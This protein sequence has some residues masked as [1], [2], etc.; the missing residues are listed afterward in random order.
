M[1][2]LHTAPGC[3]IDTARADTNPLRPGTDG[4]FTGDVIPKQFC[5]ATQNNNAGC[6][7]TDRDGRT[8]GAGLNAAGGA[9]FATLWN[10]EGVKICMCIPFSGLDILVCNVLTSLLIQGSG[11]DRMCPAISPTRP[12]TRGLGPLPRRSGPQ[13]LATLLS[14]S[15]TILL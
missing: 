7:I 8:F 3:A 12:L 6:G 13:T 2:T 10:A 1:Y 11:H 15:R 5:D 14:T 4:T 9:V